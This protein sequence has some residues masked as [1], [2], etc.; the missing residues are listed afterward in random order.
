MVSANNLIQKG[1]DR[2]QVIPEPVGIHE[3]QTGCI[4]EP[5]KR[6]AVD[7]AGERAAVELTQG[8]TSI[9]AFEIVLGPEQALSAGLALALGDGA[10]RVEPAGDGAD[11]KRFSAF[12]SVAIGRNSG[13]CAWLV[14]LVRP[15]PWM[16]ASAFQPASSR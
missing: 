12:T 8:I 3:L 7:L 13:G 16:A 5:P 11:R 9:L 14:R 15:R 2:R 1:R 4:L 6:A 10:Q